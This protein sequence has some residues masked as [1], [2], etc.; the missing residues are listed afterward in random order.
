MS[1]DILDWNSF[2]DLATPEEA[3]H[4]LQ[5]FY[6]EAAA[7]AAIRCA[8]AA[9]SD[10]RDADYRFWMAVVARLSGSAEPTLDAPMRTLGST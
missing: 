6:G 9:Q 8:I 5:E 10:T 7:E 2:W 3:A 4:T 1:E